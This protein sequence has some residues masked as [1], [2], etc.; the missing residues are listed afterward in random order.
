MAGI[1]GMV[2]ASSAKGGANHYHAKLTGYDALT[3][4]EKYDNGG[5]SQR[6]LAIEYAVAKTT[7]LNIINEKTWRNA[8]PTPETKDFF[9][10]LARNHGGPGYVLVKAIDETEARKKMFDEYG[11]KWAF[12]YRSLERV[13]VLDRTKLGQID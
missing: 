3:I 2:W 4:R 6:N 13:H 11:N 1:K 9:I 12:I 5:V 8:M 10:T 7:I